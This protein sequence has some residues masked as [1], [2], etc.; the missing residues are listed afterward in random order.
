MSG[1]LISIREGACLPKFSVMSGVT[2]VS[3]TLNLGQSRLIEDNSFLHNLRM[4]ISTTCSQSLKR[5]R[6][7]TVP[8]KYLMLLEDQYHRIRDL[9]RLLSWNTVRNRD[10]PYLCQ[11]KG[12][13]KVTSKIN[14]CAECALPKK[15]VS[16]R[17]SGS[18]DI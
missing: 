3:Q 14:H 11:R 15:T 2:S 7:E 4:M 18:P 5:K 6:K 12:N 13:I 16:F 10:A 8:R 1:L 17:S 9:V